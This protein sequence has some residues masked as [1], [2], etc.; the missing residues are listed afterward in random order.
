MTLFFDQFNICYWRTLTN[1]QPL[2]WILVHVILNVY[3]G[4]RPYTFIW[5]QSLKHYSNT[6][7][8]VVCWSLE[9][10]YLLWS[11][12]SSSRSQ[13]ESAGRASPISSSESSTQPANKDK[14]TW[15]SGKEMHFVM[16]NTKIWKTTCEPSVLPWINLH[17]FTVAFL[18]KLE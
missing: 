6:E 15:K 8:V 9:S 3:C 11:I 16:D 4:Y 12:T 17:I 18:K 1:Q 14:M 7:K 5:R 13:L 2:L 10:S